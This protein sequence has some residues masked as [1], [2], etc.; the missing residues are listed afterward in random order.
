MNEITIHQQIHQCEVIARNANGRT[1]FEIRP[2]KPMSGRQLT[3]YKQAAENN[4]LRLYWL[5]EL[6]A[7]YPE[8]TP[9]MYTPRTRKAPAM[10]D[11]A[12]PVKKPLNPYDVGV[13]VKRGDV[14]LTLIDFTDM[15]DV[16]YIVQNVPEKDIEPLFRSNI[17]LYP[18]E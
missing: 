16:G 13:Y 1:R 12:K 8:A 2:G 5:I 7:K 10:I 3:A 11:L 9:C 4:F 17:T 14:Y 6:L 15:A 18:V